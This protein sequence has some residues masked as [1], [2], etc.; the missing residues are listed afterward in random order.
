MLFVAGA[1]AGIF[2]LFAMFL[3]AI[4]LESSAAKGYCQSCNTTRKEREQWAKSHP[5]EPL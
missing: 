5:G 2:G 4:W 3:A 1:A